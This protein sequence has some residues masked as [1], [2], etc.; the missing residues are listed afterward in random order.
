[1]PDLTSYDHPPDSVDAPTNWN[2]LE[3]LKW[4]Q[5]V[6]YTRAPVVAASTPRGPRPEALSNKYGLGT[7]QGQNRQFR[8]KAGLNSAREHL[9]AR[10]LWSWALE[11]PNCTSMRW[12]F[13]SAYAAKGGTL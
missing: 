10:F 9:F 6:P 12:S 7:K 1:M 4:P 3:A 11:R 2:H 13:E 5:T 8:P